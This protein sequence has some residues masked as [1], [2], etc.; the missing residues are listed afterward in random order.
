M[1]RNSGILELKTSKS[2]LKRCFDTTRSS[3][4]TLLVLILISIVIIYGGYLIQSKYFMFSDIG[5]DT[6]ESYFMMYNNI[7]NNFSNGQTNFWDFTMGMGASVLS[8]QSVVF[9]PFAMLIYLSGM[10]FGISAIPA[11][12]IYINVIKIVCAG[13]LCYVFLNCFK[14]S[15][16]TK[17][18]AAYIYSLA[19]FMMLWGQHYFFASAV[20][21]FPIMLIAL[22]KSFDNKKFL[23]L[24]T[25]ITALVMIGGIYTAYMMLVVSFVYAIIRYFF[26]DGKHT[27]KGF[28]MQIL[29]M[30]GAVAVGVL[31]SCFIVLPAANIITNTSVRV[32]SDLTLFEKFITGFQNNFDVSYFKT[33]PYRMLSNN[34]L[35]AGSNFGGYF[36]YYEDAQ[37]FFSSLFVLLLPQ[38]LIN[39]FKKNQENRKKVLLLVA[40]VLLASIVLV[41]G[42]SSILKAFAGW[43]LRSVFV[44]LPFMALMTA[45]TLDDVFRKKLLNIPVLIVSSVLCLLVFLRAYNHQIMLH[46]SAEAVQRFQVYI[47]IFICILIAET[48]LLTA[49]SGKLKIN[50]SLILGLLMIA[51]VC[52]M[53]VDGY[54]TNNER[55]AVQREQV[56]ELYHGNIGKA[57]NFVKEYDD[58]LYRVEKDIVELSLFTEAGM[59]DYNGVSEYNS[60]MNRNLTEFKRKLWT[61]IRIQREPDSQAVY[62]M[63]TLNHNVYESLLDIKYLLTGLSEYNTDIYEPL[64]H[65]DNISVVKNKNASSFGIFFNQVMSQEEFEK[66]DSDSKEAYLYQVLISNDQLQKIQTL[67]KNEIVQK[68][69]V[70]HLPNTDDC[71]FELDK[72]S[73]VVSGTVST[74]EAGVLMISIPYEQGW[75]VYVDGQPADMIRVDYGFIGVEL[76]PGDYDILLKYTPPYLFEGTVLTFVGIG[77]LLIWIIVA[78]KKKANMNRKTHIV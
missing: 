55:P 33:F 75:N 63:D 67:S 77:I 15:N 14:L 35:G 57:V 61:Q 44:M 41:A 20:V 8:A 18:I 71:N 72:K 39:I 16:I 73:S 70:P 29:P 22:E 27:I 53:C 40:F 38:F 31:I 5:G 4:I 74:K 2:F 60:V 9:D 26:R 7:V 42:V 50:Q 64:A 28:F 23:F 24:L 17:V 6:K 25:G 54:I 34:L 76:L 58:G 78:V 10:L 69:A 32:E 37:V 48:V 45:V 46:E 19:G 43:S 59:Y 52:N 36:N 1:D 13:L 11:A 66:W 47:V 56:D 3:M 62:A 12:L 49:A 30:I 68:S 65:F 21:L 51:V